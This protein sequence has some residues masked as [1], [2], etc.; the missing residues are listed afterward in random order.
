MNLRGK[1]LKNLSQT[2]YSRHTEYIRHSDIKTILENPYEFLNKQEETKSESMLL[3]S[4]IH[5]LILEKDN[6]F[7]DFLV[8]ENVDLRT[9]DGKAKK[10]AAE[11]RAKN[12]NATLIRQSLYDKALEV[13][14]AFKNSKAYNMFKCAGLAEASYFGEIE[15]KKCKCRPDFYMEKENI[16]LDIKTTAKGGAMPDAFIKNIV[17]HKYYIQAAL[18]TKLIGAKDFYFVAVEVEAPYMIGIYKLDNVSLEFGMSEIQR[19]FKLLDS[20]DNFKDNI[21]KDTENDFN[22]VQSLTLP[23]YVYYQK[24][25]SYGWFERKEAR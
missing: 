19:A 25:A 7:N 9:K 8:M 6:F 5:S 2:E 20:L 24:G 4:V 10:Q 11:E 15:G 12:F 22:M 13:V 16:I 1:W 23:N 21:Y 3:G 14:N 17:K 18:Y